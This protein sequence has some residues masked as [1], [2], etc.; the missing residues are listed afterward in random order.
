MLDCLVTQQT[1]NAMTSYLSNGSKIRYLIS[2]SGIFYQFWI[3]HFWIPHFWIPHFWIYHFWIP[4][5]W[6]WNFLPMLLS[7]IF[8]HIDSFVLVEN[9]IGNAQVENSRGGSLF[10]T[11]VLTVLEFRVK[12]VSNR[13]QSNSSFEPFRIPKIPQM[14]LSSNPFLFVPIKWFESW[15]RV[16]S[17]NDE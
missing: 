1:S 9:E 12:N 2:G 16:Q 14:V 17:Y 13:K 3:P 15:L 11:F 4:H 8:C 6:V 7:V 5:F 10:K